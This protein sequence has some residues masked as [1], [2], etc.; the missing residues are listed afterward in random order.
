MNTITFEEYLKVDIRVGKIEEAIRIPK[1]KKLIKMLVCFGGGDIRQIVTNIGTHYEPEQLVNLKTTF[2]TNLEPTTIMGV[3][4]KG[5]LFA[6]S[7]EDGS[8]VILSV[9]DDVLLGSKVG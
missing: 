2:V 3:E 8:A 9:G 5:M 7:R 4:S 1:S 6:A